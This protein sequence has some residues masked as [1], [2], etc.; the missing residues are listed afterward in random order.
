[1]EASWRQAI[2]DFDIQ[3]LTEVSERVRRLD[4]SV[5]DV[6]SLSNDVVAIFDDL[7]DMKANVPL[8]GSISAMDVVREAFPGVG[9]AEEV[10]RAL[11]TEL[12]ELEDNS[13]SLR[14]ASRR[15]QSLELSSVSGG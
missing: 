2:G 13:A 3:K 11:D 12:N 6:R 4:E 14:R 9:D 8:L 10:I 5:S 15:I 1:M 7:D